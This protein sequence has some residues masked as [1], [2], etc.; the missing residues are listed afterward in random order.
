MKYLL[1]TSFDVV[2]YMLVVFLL[3]ARKCYESLSCSPNSR[4]YY[5]RQETFIIRCFK[6]WVFMTE[7]SW[8]EFLKRQVF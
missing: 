8:L 3:L 7:K 2:T 5:C 6:L 1:L 4:P